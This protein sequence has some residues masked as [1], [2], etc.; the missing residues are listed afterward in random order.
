[1]PL[2]FTD[3]QQW[4]DKIA[5][6]L[7][8]IADDIELL[9][10]MPGGDDRPHY[11]E[12]KSIADHVEDAAETLHRGVRAGKLSPDDIARIGNHFADAGRELAEGGRRRA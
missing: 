10:R 12:L 4:A 1:M 7:A 6:A 11:P 2:G 8:R 9:V 3:E 5:K